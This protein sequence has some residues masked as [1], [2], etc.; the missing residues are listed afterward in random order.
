MTTSYPKE[1]NLDH[2][3][4]ASALLLSTA[5]MLYRLVLPP[6]YVLFAGVTNDS[7]GGLVLKWTLIKPINTCTKLCTPNYEVIRGGDFP[8]HR[9]TPLKDKP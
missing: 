3:T 9:F 2:L 5:K 4:T 7:Q 8:T 6:D 1:S